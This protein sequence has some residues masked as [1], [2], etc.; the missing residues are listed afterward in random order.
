MSFA[1]RLLLGSLCLLAAAGAPGAARAD[2]E[3]A[4]AAAF[5]GSSAEELRRVLPRDKKVLLAVTPVHEEERHFGPDQVYYLFETFFESHP[6]ISFRLRRK[7]D[8]DGGDRQMVHADWRYQAK[9]GAKS[10]PL[11]IT[12]AEEGGRWVVTALRSARQ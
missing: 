11:V 3:A 4:L 10:E 9:G 1:V 6:T 8:G 2:A 5:S 7:D 12:L